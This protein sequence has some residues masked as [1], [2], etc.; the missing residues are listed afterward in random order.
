MFRSGVI[1]VIC[2]ISMCSSSPGFGK[3]KQTD[4]FSPRDCERC[5]AGNFA[6]NV[7]LKAQGE[8]GGQSAGQY[9]SMFSLFFKSLQSVRPSKSPYNLASP[10][11]WEDRDQ[12]VTWWRAGDWLGSLRDRQRPQI[13][14][15]Q[16]TSSAATW[17]QSI[18]RAELSPYSH[19]TSWSR[20]RH[21]WWQQTSPSLSLITASY[22]ARDAGGLQSFSS[23][24]LY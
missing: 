5:K 2:L 12:L 15:D 3:L 10:S 20:A 24:P 16:I 6:R 1:P 11:A 21:L 18:T 19:L 22:I 8:D 17:L 23:A 14:D 4:G 13:T 7:F 9:Y